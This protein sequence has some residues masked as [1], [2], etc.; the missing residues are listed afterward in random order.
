MTDTAAAPVTEAVAPRPKG[1]TWEPS[2]MKEGMDYAK[3]L[4]QSSLIPVYLRGKPHDVM[5]VALAG[6]DYGLTFTQAMQSVIVVEGKVALSAALIVGLVKKS[7]DCE[8]FRIVESDSKHAIWET[9]RAGSPAPTRLGFTIQ[10][11]ALM[12]LDQRSN[13]K[14]QPETMLLWRCATRL[15]RMEY[16]DLVLN[17][18]DIDEAGDAGMLRLNATTGNWQPPEGP[19]AAATPG[20]N[21]P[22]PVGGTPPAATGA[23]AP[24]ATLPQAAPPAATPTQETKR[25]PGRPRKDGQPPGGKTAAVPH[26][27]QPAPP[28]PGSDPVLPLSEEGSDEP[29]GLSEDEEPSLD[30]DE[31]EE[32][33]GDPNE[34]ERNVLEGMKPDERESH[35]GR[36]LM[37]LLESKQSLTPEPDRYDGWSNEVRQSYWRARLN[38][39]STEKEARAAAAEVQAKE[40]QGS[41]VRKGL[42]EVYNAKLRALGVE[43]KR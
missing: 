5:V 7:R 2:N 28:A 14:K 18:L 23:P 16:P 27:G 33:P 35:F 9:K 43:P 19:P 20:G 36:E 6:R 30:G 12:G 3:W 42:G 29:G 34:V 17:L 37:K 38:F 24:A 39:A 10:D 22:P 1:M 8:Y 41:L 13:W 15:A 4:A 26:G 25:G 31:L 21:V 32:E 11:A 40:P